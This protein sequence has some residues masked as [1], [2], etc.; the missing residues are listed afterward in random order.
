MATDNPFNITSKFTDSQGTEHLVTVRAPTFDQFRTYLGQISTIFLN[1]A[2]GDPL[3]QPGDEEKVP[4]N[5]A[6]ARREVEVQ[7]VKAAHTALRREQALSNNGHQCP[8]HG[9]AATSR[10]TGGLYCPTQLDDGSWCRWTAPAPA[11]AATS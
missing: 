5:I 4:T 1:M 9:R 3:P 7:Q 8:E 2:F 10:Y 11:K 6:T